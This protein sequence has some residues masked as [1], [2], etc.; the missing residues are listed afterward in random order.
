MEVFLI[1]FAALFFIL[2]VGGAL[3]YPSATRRRQTTLEPGS[4]GSGVGSRSA[5][6]VLDGEDLSADQ[7]EQV[8]EALAPAAPEVLARPRFRDRLGKARGLFGEYVGLITGRSDI[9][10][11]TWDELEEALIRADVGVKTSTAILDDLRQRVKSEGIKTPT[12]LIEALKSDLKK[13]LASGNRDL[14]LELDLYFMA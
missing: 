3:L 7:V 4:A 14:R 2:I 9:D 12:E 10:Q 6:A 11:D 13:S 8:E 1:S 5:T